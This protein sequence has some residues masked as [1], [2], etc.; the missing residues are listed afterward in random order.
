MSRD[1]GIETFEGLE[2]PRDDDLKL[3]VGVK[4]LRDEGTIRDS[5][6]SNNGNRRPSII[7]EIPKRT[8]DYYRDFR[9]VN[10]TIL[11]KDEPLEA[12]LTLE[13]NQIF[14]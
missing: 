9:E 4:P 6:I 2:L 10:L 7:I 13:V 14:K 3:V 1:D 5:S 11:L 8:I 12:L